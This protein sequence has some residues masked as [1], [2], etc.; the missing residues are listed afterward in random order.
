MIAIFVKSFLNRFP[1]MIDLDNAVQSH[2]IY[3]H[4]IYIISLLYCR[5]VQTG[6]DII[7]YAILC[8]RRRII[9]YR[10]VRES[11]CRGRVEKLE[12]WKLLAFAPI[13]K[14]TIYFSAAE[15]NLKE[16]EAY[17]TTALVPIY[18][19][20]AHLLAHSLSYSL[21]LSTYIMYYIK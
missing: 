18:P 21:T 20:A 4:I 5:I 13:I 3:L 16:K 7:Q 8:A 12:G 1:P 10:V 11:R 15:Y 19:P 17:T 2:I 14:R 9:P 6:P